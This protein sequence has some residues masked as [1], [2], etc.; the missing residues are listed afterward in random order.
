MYYHLT[1]EELQKFVNDVNKEIKD[2]NEV[3]LT[4]TNKDVHISVPLSK[5]DKLILCD[6]NKDYSYIYFDFK[7]YF[8]TGLSVYRD[9]IKLEY[10]YKTYD[11]IENYHKLH[12]RNSNIII[13]YY[14][15]YDET[16]VKEK[17][18]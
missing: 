7:K 9:I 15:E 12:L 14:N 5:E 8:L 1:K 3:I 4:V 11:S 13:E 10:V 17:N 2:S 6:E 18:D 16:I